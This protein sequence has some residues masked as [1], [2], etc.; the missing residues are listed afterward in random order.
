M[1]TDRG[2]YVLR[3]AIDSFF[4][5][6]SITH[7]IL[8]LLPLRVALTSKKRLSQHFGKTKATLVGS[9]KVKVP[10]MSERGVSPI[11]VFLVP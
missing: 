11:I 6:K 7:T 4:Q 2:K 8:F 9:T 10:S 5:R 1:P 3:H